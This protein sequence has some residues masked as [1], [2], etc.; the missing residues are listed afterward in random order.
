M[1]SH[2]HDWQEE[3]KVYWAI[4]KH[5]QYCH[6]YICGRSYLCYYDNEIP[7]LIVDGVHYKQRYLRSE[8]FDQYI[9]P[10]RTDFNDSL[11]KRIGQP[12]FV[13]DIDDRQKRYPLIYPGS[14]YTLNKKIPKLSEIGLYE[15]PQE[16]Y[17]RINEYMSN[18]LRENPDTSPPVEISNSGK[19]TAH[20][21]DL[22]ESFRKIK[23]KIISR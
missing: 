23:N 9:R 12:V 6:V 13:I 10:I 3:D 21:F 2:C 14:S 8:Y 16:I 7:R 4:E 5:F 15:T 20:G 18:V 11:S 19:I 22:K 17:F 1:E